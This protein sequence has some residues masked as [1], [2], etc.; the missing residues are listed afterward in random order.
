MSE[1]NGKV[2]IITGASS[3]IGRATARKLGQEGAKVVLAARRENRL[4]ELAEEIQSLGGDI[5][6]L[7]VTDVTLRKDVEELEAWQY[8]SSVK[9]MY[10]SI[11]QE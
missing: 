3:G 7:K 1:I 8:N 6:I 11:M 9:L 5:R 10:F 4:Q 2:I